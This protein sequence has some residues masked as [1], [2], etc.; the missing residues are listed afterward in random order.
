MAKACEHVLMSHF[1]VDYTQWCN[2]IRN[3][4][5]KRGKKPSIWKLE[6]MVLNNSWVKVEITVG[7]MK[8]LKLNDSEIVPYLNCQHAAREGL[9]K[10]IITLNTQILK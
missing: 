10:D 4:L 5:G 8:H 1:T 6:N 3:Q 9:K 2:K 7:F